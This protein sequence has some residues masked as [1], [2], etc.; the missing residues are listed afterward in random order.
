MKRPFFIAILLS[1]A[2]SIYA[3]EVDYEYGDPSELKGMTKVFVDPSGD[4]QL[5]PK[6]T[7]ALAQKIPALVFVDDYD[8]AEFTI[9]FN[10]NGT[11]GGWVVATQS[12]KNPERPRVLMTLRY[13]KVYPWQSGFVDKFVSEF[14]KTYK[15]ANK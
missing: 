7:K 11:G 9:V 2:L 1:A 6:I 14:M 4:M 15:K 5:R 8:D 3:Q 10:Q 12:K 13:W